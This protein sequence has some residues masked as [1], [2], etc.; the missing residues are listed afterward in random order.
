MNLNLGRVVMVVALSVAAG[1]VS[2]PAR[3][4]QRE[5][6]VFASFPE[7]IQARVQRGEVA[8]GFTRDMVRLAL[9]Q[10]HRVI[11]RV[12]GS[13]QVDIWV[14]TGSRYISR[15]EPVAGGYWYQ[16]RAGRLFRSTDIVWMDRGYREEFP[17]M[18]IEFA[19]DKVTSFE[20]IQR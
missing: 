17:V 18:R 16:D 8:V 3:R 6:E 13:G 12:T 5:P 10:P 14:Y 4:I 1:C 7:D 2:T 20:R 9:G 19:G 15:Y 11:N